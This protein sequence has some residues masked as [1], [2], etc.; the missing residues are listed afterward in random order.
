[1]KTMMPAAFAAAL[2]L[3]T[4]GCNQQPAASDQAAAG[5]AI[6]GTWKADLASVQIDEKPSIYLLRDG[7]YACE[8]CVPPLTVQADGAFH[9]VADRPY[10]DS[11][12]VEV[13][14]DRTVKTV[15]RKGE[16]IVGESTV[17]V[18]PDGNT[19]AFTFSNSPTPGTP[20]VTGSGT[21]TRVGPAPAGAH[22]ISG[23]WKTAKY[24]TVSD[25]GLT[26]TFDLEGDTLSMTAPTGESYAA[27]IDGG[28]VP[29]NGDEGGTVVSVRRLGANQFEE[30]FMRDGKPVSVTTM[31][32]NGDG[33]MSSVSEN[34]LQD[35]KMT[36]TSRKQ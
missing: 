4:A 7:T 27:T 35:S 36:Y 13:V 15:R 12:S 17:T 30:T 10:Y 21:D 2:L 5:D 25:E 8:T 31:T 14:D 24:D 29:V 11:M 28:E 16:R 3:A 34:K 9:P 6:D 20:P 26:V 23:S 22:A 1:M 33:T 19:A 18:A 32:V